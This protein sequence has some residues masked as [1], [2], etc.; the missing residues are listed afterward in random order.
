MTF[1][2]DELML[3][4][5]AVMKEESRLRDIE[6]SIRKY[7]KNVSDDAA[8]LPIR[9]QLNAERLAHNKIINKL[10]ELMDQAERQ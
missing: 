1:T 7:S 3:L 6:Y 10:I 5:N 9:Q 4:H 2:S 8:L